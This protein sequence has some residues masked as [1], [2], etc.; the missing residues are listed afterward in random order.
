MP[1]ETFRR[2]GTDRELADQFRIVHG[3]C[4]VRG[5]EH[6]HAWVEQGPY[7]WQAAL[8]LDGSRIYY[9]VRTVELYA[10][11]GVSRILRYNLR[12]A[13]GHNARTA[14]FGPWDETI[15]ALCAD[16]GPREL[17]TIRYPNVLCMVE[18]RSW[19]D[20]PAARAWLALAEQETCEGCGSP[21]ERCGPALWAQQKKCCPDCSHEPPRLD[22][23]PPAPEA[24]IV[25][26]VRQ[27]RGTQ[28]Q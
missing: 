7:A 11:R 13:L 23:E 18:A 26:V 3:V 2:L 15:K 5:V 9:A 6:A 10:A 19:V 8:L 27:T 28:T 17:G 1:F 20:D 12:S 14:S 24:V 4:N 22:V 21:Y 25:T 16:N